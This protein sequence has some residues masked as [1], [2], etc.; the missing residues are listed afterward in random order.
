MGPIFVLSDIFDC[1]SVSN[2]DN[3]R[4]HVKSKAVLGVPD[5][6]L[7]LVQEILSSS[8]FIEEKFGWSVDCSSNCRLSYEGLP[9]FN[10]PIARCLS[11]P[12][13]YL[14]HMWH[15]NFS[16]IRRDRAVPLPLCFWLLQDCPWFAWSKRS[17]P[18]L[19]FLSGHL[20]SRNIVAIAS[21]LTPRTIS[22]YWFLVVDT[23]STS[24]LTEETSCAAA[25][26]VE[27]RWLLDILADE[28]RMNEL[29]DSG[30]S[31][32]LPVS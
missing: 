18:C 20:Y 8:W 7:V 17:V 1:I 16:F 24:C 27:T 9:R 11:C 5:L 31:S 6:D 21:R 28:I 22:A 12:C 3:C 10:G 30:S 13:P 25:A 19:L 23:T 2:E 26:R 32:G 4:K 29:N 14:P 15:G